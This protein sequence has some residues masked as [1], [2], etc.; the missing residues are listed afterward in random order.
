MKLLVPFCSGQRQVRRDRERQETSLWPL[1][2]TCA[3]ATGKSVVLA[4]LCATELT[5]ARLPIHPE[6]GK[7]PDEAKARGR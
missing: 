5:R 7:F 6:Y 3:R 2:R 4:I 1:C